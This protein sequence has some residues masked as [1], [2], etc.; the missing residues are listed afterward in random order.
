MRRL[1]TLLLRPALWLLQWLL[2]LFLLF[3][4]WGWEPLA[5]L[6]GQLARLPIIGWLERR[7]A[8]LPPYGALAVFFLPALLLLPVKLLA[9]W[10]ISQGRTLLGV[11]VIVAAKL[12]GTAIVARLFMLTQGQLMQLAWFARLY[13][14]WINWKEALLARVRASRPWRIARWLKLRARRLWRHRAAA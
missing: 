14:R 5:R 4:E 2:A 3:E 7:I 1:I 12:I 13:S 9:L 6:L 11:T 8:A 10:L